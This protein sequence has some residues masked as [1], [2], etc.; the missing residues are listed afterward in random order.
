MP[1][2]LKNFIMNIGTSR[3]KH[4]KNPKN[5]DENCRNISKK[6]GRNEGKERRLR[7]QKS[8][9]NRKGLTVAPTQ[10]GVGTL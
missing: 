1:D 5:P 2:P 8:K 7:R 4:P 9:S 3:I 6:K 10:P